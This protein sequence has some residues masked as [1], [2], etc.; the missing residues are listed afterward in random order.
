MNEVVPTILT[1]DINDFTNKIKLV[2]NIS[3][4]VQIDVV[5]GIFAKI[6]TIDLGAVRDLGETGELKIDLH[7][8]VEE[9][10]GWV[11]R[12]L[13]LV[14]DRIIAHIEKMDDPASFINEVINSGMEVGLAIDLNTSLESVREDVLLLADMVL[15]LGVKA[16]ESGQIFDKI[17]LE[18][19][20]KVREILK[21]LGKIGVDGGIN[22]ENIKLCKEAGANIFYVGNYLWEAE[23]TGKRYNELLTLVN[24]SR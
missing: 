14:P 4:R 19:I 20:N 10:M 13:E 23:D 9:P 5:D 16:G 22:L 24:D 7:L 21:D 18:K 11:K 15:I 1:S 8:M 6:K 17:A 12:C 2:K 3:S